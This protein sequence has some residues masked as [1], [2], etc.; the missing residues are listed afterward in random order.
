MGVVEAGA[1]PLHSPSPPAPGPEEV[2]FRQVGLPFRERG[3][4]SP[5]GM[6]EGGHVCERSASPEQRGVGL[7]VG[8]AGLASGEPAHSQPNPLPGAGPRPQLHPPHPR[9]WQGREGG[10]G[11]ALGRRVVGGH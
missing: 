4:V 7:G 8:K 3:R 2:F 10:S 11:A 9:P 1:Q 6:L 5:V